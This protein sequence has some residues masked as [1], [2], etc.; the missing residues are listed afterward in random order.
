MVK[1]IRNR[2]F[3]FE[4]Q[5]K[6]DYWDWSSEDKALFDNWQENKQEIFQIIFDRI[7]QLVEDDEFVEVALVVHDKDMSYGT[8]LVEPHIHAYIDFPKR[9]DL[10][11]LSMTLGLE[12]ERLET[13]KSKGGRA[14]TRINALAYLIHAK[15]KD[16]YQYPVSDVETF[17]TL[18][19]ERFIEQNRT[20]FDNYAATRKRE[21]SDERLD[22]V[23]D[24]IV[25]GELTEDDILDDDGLRYLWSHNQQKF[26]EAFK[27]YGK[28]SSRLTLKAIERGDFKPTV[29]YIHG[30]S[31]VGKTY[32]ANELITRIGLK[33]KAEGYNWNRYDA[34]TKNIFDEYFGEEIILLDDPRYDSLL[35]SDWLK[36][37]DPLNK[38]HLSARYKN[39][40][41]IGRI[42]VITN[43]M[44][45]SEFFGQIPKE[46]LN[47]Y[48][49]RFHNVI[50]ITK[51][52]T[53]RQHRLSE[54]R[55]LTVPNTDGYKMLNF[56]EF[57]VLSDY[58]QD[59]FL[60]KI[61]EDYIYPRILPKQRKDVTDKG[62]NQRE[63]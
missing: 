13:P 56:G 59:Q 37:L 35:P 62:G 47:Q 7:R 6:A 58:Q 31:G 23:Y 4:Q 40:L 45:L 41:V 46:D 44:S 5:L 26:D 20:D 57:E 34:G 61:L 50:E 1:R 38:S 12:R 25:R 54:I 43:Y 21:K 39:K 55:E 18:D 8:K 60:D 19:Y 52:G 11:R 49:R 22:L 24:Q 53:M 2:R 9:I 28:I 48:L 63:E 3:L 10:S 16:K 51:L 33:A 14:Y 27:A 30:Q 36:L 32:L 29:L 17:G 42:I 15:D